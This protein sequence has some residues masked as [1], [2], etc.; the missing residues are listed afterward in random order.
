MQFLI[1]IIKWQ[2][3]S[4]ILGNS[5]ASNRLS[6]GFFG[7]SL[8][9]DYSNWLSSN[10]RFANNLLSSHNNKLPRSDLWMRS[11]LAIYPCIGYLVILLLY[12]AWTTKAWRSLYFL[13]PFYPPT[14]PRASTGGTRVEL[15]WTYIGNA[16]TMHFVGWLPQSV[17]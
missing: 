4:L 7:L 9:C 8:T 16:F 5:I 15:V 2:W 10:L 12:T 11:R 17:Q 1:S 3:R 14:P 13:Q 6:F